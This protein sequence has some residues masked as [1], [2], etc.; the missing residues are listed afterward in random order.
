MYKNIP[1]KLKDLNIW[2]CYDAKSDNPKAPRDIKGKK[3]SINGRLYS[4]NQCI[5][6]IKNGFNTGLGI[7]L[8]NNGLVCI[9]YDNCIKGYEVNKDLGYK[10]PL[11]IDADTEKRILRDIN[12]I[13]SY[14]EISPSGKGIH[15]YL[16]A[17]TDLRV[18]ANKDNIE[19]YTNHFIRVSDDLFNEFLYNDIDD[20][21]SELEQ[22]LKIYGL[23]DAIEHKKDII[24]KKS[25]NLYNQMQTQQFKYTN[26]LT[27]SK[28]LN[29]L[30][31]SK[32]GHLIEKLYHNDITDK[33]FYTLKGKINASD[34]VI[35][36]IDTSDSGKSITL[37]FYLYDISYGDIDI[38]YKLFKKSELCKD[39]YI[40]KDRANNTKDIIEHN[41]IPY[42]ITNYINYR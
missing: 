41:F 9:D 37:L 39:K 19:I 25:N 29:R 16:L 5:D 36:K 7:V 34:K 38:V 4:Y 3:H 35:D 20:K 42:V 23:S 10:K 11:F 17:N 21:T 28:V 22:L 1:K 12:L 8:K 18:N 33:E 15:I 6:S 26:Q 40:R 30:F 27:A 2:L 13:D 32:K 14:T 31:M 24:R